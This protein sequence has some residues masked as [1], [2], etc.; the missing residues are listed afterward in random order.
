MDDRLK[1]LSLFSG[2]GG[3]DLAMSP[4]VRTIGYCDIEEYSQKVL[5]ARMKSGELDDAPIYT[6]VTKL[7]IEK[8]DTPEPAD[9]IHGGFP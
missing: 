9:I 5:K 3:I 7:C 4:W 2:I 1:A 6:D 8:G